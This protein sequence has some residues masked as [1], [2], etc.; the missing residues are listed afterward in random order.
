VLLLRNVLVLLA[1]TLALV[2][3][4]LGEE[5]NS[6]RFLCAGGGM[7]WLSAMVMMMING[8]NGQFSEN[9]PVR[10]VFAL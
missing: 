8:E 3:G 9:V 4:D 10:A 7:V 5:L 1:R 6:G 2:V